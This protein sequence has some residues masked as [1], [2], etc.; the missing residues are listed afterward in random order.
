VAGREA[1]RP[2]LGVRRIP[3]LAALI[4]IV[5]VLLVFNLSTW[6]LLRRFEASKE[7]DLA[8]RL[9]F[10]ARTVARDLEREG[11]PLVL[12]VVRTQPVEDGQR[13]IGA[14]AGTGSQRDLAA[15]LAALQ[16]F[17]DLAQTVLITPRGT[18]VADSLGRWDPG[19]PYPLM[20]LDR[21]A[22]EEAAAG[23]PATTALYYLDMEGDRRPYKRAY[24]PMGS[25]G[26]PAPLAIV[27]VSVS[28]PYV[29]AIADLR[30]RVTTQ[31]LLSSVLL[32]LIG[33]SIYRLFSYAV[34]AE[35]SALRAARVDAMGA[36][37]AGVA[38]ELRNPLAIVRA[39]SE[40]IAAE[41]PADTQV[42]RNARDI[43]TEVSRL[44]ELVSH[45]L[46]LSRPPELGDTRAVDLAAE[47]GRVIALMRKSAPRCVVFTEELPSAPLLVQAAEPALRQLFLNLLL[48]A[49][50][51][52]PQ[53][54]GGTVRV[55]ARARRSMAEVLIADTGAGITP[56]DLSRVF[57]PFH[58]TKPGGTG[59][60]LAIS[61]AIVEALGGTIELDS[62]PG[63]GTTVIVRLP[64]APASGT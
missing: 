43:M 17:L 13:V 20:D 7:V 61:R 3:P 21:T 11:T 8:E 57:E 34:A 63:R 16:D 32:V 29:S 18:V 26:N 52:L 12:S 28:P 58:T 49:R 55:C 59:L 24:V 48:N 62:T 64:L 50:E 37:A 46:S 53:D 25:D 6:R 45:F 10:A 56:R 15:R 30:R 38:H 33:Y 1:S 44:N 36:L 42:A 40:E 54:T 27:Q 22:F 5:A 31:M 60:G 35:R 39:L 51:A 23:K 19:D 4:F 47:L 41:A 14:M 9:V 2:R